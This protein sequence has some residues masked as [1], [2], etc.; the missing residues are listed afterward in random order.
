MSSCNKPKNSPNSPK[1]KTKKKTSRKNPLRQ[2]VSFNSMSNML[3]AFAIKKRNM[4]EIFQN[5]N[6]KLKR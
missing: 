2:G 5:I 1:Q 3:K 6:D 4:P